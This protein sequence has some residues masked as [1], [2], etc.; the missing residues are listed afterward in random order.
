MSVIKNSIDLAL[1]ASSIRVLSTNVEFTSIGGSSFTNTDGIVSPSIITLTAVTT[2]FTSAHTT[3][4]QYKPSTSDNWSLVTDLQG[5]I[6]GAQGDTLTV[7]SL[8]YSTNIST[9]SFIAYRSTT[10]QYLYTDAVGI[11]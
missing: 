11:Y 10:S 9:G 5:S 3:R 4:W 6:S 2:G 7:T 8:Q 1:Q